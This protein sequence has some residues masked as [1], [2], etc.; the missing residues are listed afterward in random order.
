MQTPGLLFIWLS[1]C[2][3]KESFFLRLHLVANIRQE[4]MNVLV[5]LLE[6][7]NPLIFQH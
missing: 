1:S 4:A 3:N 7:E 6:M 2:W 5:A